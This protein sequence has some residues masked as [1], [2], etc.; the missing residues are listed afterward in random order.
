MQY[1]S[2]ENMGGMLIRRDGFL[3]WSCQHCKKQGKSEQ[4]LARCPKCDRQ[5]KEKK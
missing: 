5:K 2:Y 3:H 4:V 1:L